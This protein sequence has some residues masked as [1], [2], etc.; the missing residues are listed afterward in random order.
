MTNTVS[1]SEPCNCDCSARSR[2]GL[3]DN[4]YPPRVPAR[5]N[6]YWRYLPCGMTA[7]FPVSGSPLPSG[8]IT[9][10]PRH[11]SICGRHCPVFGRHSGNKPF[12]CSRRRKPRYASIFPTPSVMS[13]FSIR[14]RH[15]RL[16]A[17]YR[18]NA[19][20]GTFPVS[21]PAPAGVRGGVDHGRARRPACKP[22]SRR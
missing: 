5:S 1:K 22:T 8:R 7:T 12:A 4:L 2:C 10:R 9:T 21:R 20:R 14:R 15:A 17:R 3:P 18:R 16:Q 11:F 6:G 19:S 13:S